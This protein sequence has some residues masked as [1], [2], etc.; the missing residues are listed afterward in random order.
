MN[1]GNNGAVKSATVAGLLGIFLGGIGAH[2]W[3]LGEKKKGIIHLVL[4]GAGLFLII[5]AGTILPAVLPLMTVYRM[6]GFLSLLVSLGGLVISGNSLWGFI[7][8][9]VI[10]VQ[11]DAGLA[12]KGIAVANATAPAAPVAPAQPAPAP[13]PAPAAPV[14]EVKPEAAPAAEPKVEAAPATP[15]P[16]AEAKPAEEA[17]KPEGTAA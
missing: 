7:E 10:L 9:I 2:N 1:N 12:R 13:T 4:I 15:A 8:G 16:A 3:Y 11:G 6:L 14:A 5:L 17:A